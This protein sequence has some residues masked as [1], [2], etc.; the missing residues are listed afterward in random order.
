M[1]TT[2]YVLNLGHE[3][4]YIDKSKNIE[5]KFEQHLNDLGSSFTK[6]T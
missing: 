4:Y 3:C 1:T 2:I 6:K 5:K